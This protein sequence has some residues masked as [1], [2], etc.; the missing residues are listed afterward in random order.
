MHDIAEVALR[1]SYEAG[2]LAAVLF[3]LFGLDDLAV[4]ALRM[5][6]YGRG[7]PMR[8]HSGAA[9]ARRFAIFIPAWRESAVIAPM[10]AHMTRMWPQADLRFYVGV[11]PND[12]ATMVAVMHA[13]QADARVQMVINPK[14]GPTT[15]GDGLNQMWHHMRRDGQR[16][17]FCADAIILHDAEDV[18]CA[19]EPA[20]LDAALREADY[21]QIPVAPLIDR[22][23]NW[24]A[25][26]YADEF[27]ESHGRDL[28]VRAAI[29]AAMPMAGVGCAFCVRALAQLAGADGPF[30]DG[31]LTE[32]YELGLR[33][34]AAGGRARFVQ[35]VDERGDAIVSRAYF[36]DRLPAAVRQKTRWIRGTA[37][38]GW[39]RLGWPM[40]SGASATQRMVQGWMLWRDRR[41]ILSALAIILAYVAMVLA[42]LAWTVADGS[43]GAIAGTPSFA[44]RMG[45]MDGPGVRLL[46]AF[47][48]VI[49][50]WRLVMRAYYTGR[51]YGAAQWPWAVVRQLGSNIILIMTGWRA[52]YD[53][54]RA[55]RGAAPVWDK[56][57]HHFPAETTLPHTQRATGPHGNGTPWA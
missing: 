33:L 25:H 50:L 36:P 34:H 4:D 46:L 11:Y 17:R 23:T 30:A 27:A 19:A 47:N 18:V 55:R 32:D 6:G 3:A 9:L 44:A 8:V 12:S 10:L 43:A 37:L 21:A 41:V 35:A 22:R 14:N 28:P 42:L 7:A 56:T 45:A 54:A 26:H 40:R 1:I 49:L 20:A 29:G 39:D 38:H 5:A 52:F 53:Y 51:R 57:D 15:K 31:S 24:V 13:V 48:S 2:L 16:G